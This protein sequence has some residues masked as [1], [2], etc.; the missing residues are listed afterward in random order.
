MTTMRLLSV[1]ASLVLL[2]AGQGCQSP[3]RM[4]EQHDHA[5]LAEYYTDE[6]QELR[7]EAK[8]WDSMAE[9]YEKHP[10]PDT[11]NIVPSKR[12]AAHSREIAKNDR[13]A[14]DD[15]EALAAKHRTLLPTR[16]SS[17]N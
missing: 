11:E 6:A 9:L 5:G 12:L 14:A 16:P 7:D 1:P 10:D 15:I 8:H 4:I 2:L 3:Q 13:E 17:K